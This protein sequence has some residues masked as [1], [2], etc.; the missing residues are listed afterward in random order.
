MTHAQF[1][2]GLQTICKRAAKVK[3]NSRSTSVKPAERLLTALRA[4]T[5]PRDTGLS[6]AKWRATIDR[7]L[8]DLEAEGLIDIVKDLA[9]GGVGLEHVLPHAGV[10][11]PLAGED[12]RGLVL[13]IFEGE[14]YSG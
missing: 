14:S 4:L 2:A 8:R 12:E 1:A 3:A 6:Q 11:A 10:L 13:H 7:Q 9:R 5:P